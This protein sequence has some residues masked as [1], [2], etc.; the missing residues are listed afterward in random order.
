MVLVFAVRTALTTPVDLGRDSAEEVS[1]P[2]RSI[3]ARL[4]EG[5]W[6]CFGWLEGGQ[7]VNPSWSEN[8]IPAGRD[9]ILAT[10]GPARLRSCI[11]V[12]TS[13]S[14]ALATWSAPNRRW[15]HDEGVEKRAQRLEA[16]G[17]HN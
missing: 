11:S 13:P 10:Q 6:L 9:R 15:P 17:P 2:A 8:P 12:G 7:G 1:H 5:A 4:R 3:T 16:T 14:T